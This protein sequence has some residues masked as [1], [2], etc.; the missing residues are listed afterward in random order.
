[1]LRLRKIGFNQQKNY[2]QVCIFP[3]FVYFVR[4]DYYDCLIF[5][6]ADGILVKRLKHVLDRVIDEENV[7]LI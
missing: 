7:S 2:Q 3:S 4:A 5:S 1:M 6:D